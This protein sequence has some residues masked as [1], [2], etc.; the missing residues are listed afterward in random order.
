MQ[1]FVDFGSCAS[2]WNS[3][4]NNVWLICEMASLGSALGLNSEK[5][6]LRIQ[7]AW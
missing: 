3:S 4:G 5:W 2:R 6:C 7:G 1:T